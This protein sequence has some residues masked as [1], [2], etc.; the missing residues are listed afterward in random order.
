MSQSAFETQTTLTGL[1]KD[2]YEDKVVNLVP[3]SSVHTEKN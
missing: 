1:F 2:V 3:E